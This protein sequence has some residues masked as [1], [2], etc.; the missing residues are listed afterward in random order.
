MSSGKLD[1]GWVAWTVVAASFMI[2]FLIYG[3]RFSTIFHLRSQKIV[4]FPPTSCILRMFHK[5]STALL[6]AVFLSK[7]CIFQLLLWHS[8]ACHC[9]SFQSW[10]CRGSAH[11]LL[12]DSSHP[13]IRWA[14]GKAHNRWFDRCI[15]ELGD[16]NIQL[17]YPRIQ[18]F[19]IRYNRQTTMVENNDH[20]L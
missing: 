14:L 12:H 6:L 16:T 19:H 9:R 10:S 3:F 17:G 7:C 1:G 5:I 15:F 2:Y 4:S 18:E 8:P 20:L 11:L 13:W